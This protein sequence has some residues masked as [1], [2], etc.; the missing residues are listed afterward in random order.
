MADVRVE[1]AGA[2]ATGRGLEVHDA[3][4]AQIDR[5]DVVRSGS[6]QQ[7]VEPGIAEHGEE[8]DAV[9]LQ[10]RLAARH[11]DQRAAE[12]ADFLHNLLERHFVSFVEGVFRVAISAAQVA[13]SEAHEDTGQT[14]PSAL[15]LHRL[16]DFVDREF[17]HRAQRSG[18]E[19]SGQPDNSLLR[20]GRKRTKIVAS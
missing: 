15:A 14:G 10:Q 9:G 1:I 4:H 18:G 11:L 8:R 13:E 12:T 3:V 6:F 2:L 16:V 17:F 20:R 7:D 19:A 5:R